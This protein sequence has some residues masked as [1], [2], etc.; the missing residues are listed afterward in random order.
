[1]KNKIFSINQLSTLLKKKGINK[2]NIILCHGV[3]DVIHLGHIKYF[4]SAKKINGDKNNFLIVTATADKFINK[5][6]NRPFFNETVRSEMLSSIEIIDAVAISN[7]ASS[8]EVI[9][10]I[11]P[12]YYVK[13][14]DYKDNTLDKSGKIYL[15][16]KAVKKFGGK[17]F[18]TKDE[19]YSS[20]KILN[21]SEF[22]FS[23]EQREILKKIK[24]KFDFAYVEKKI[25]DLKKIDV[26]VLGEI[27]FD[28]YIFG[29]VI[30]KSGKEPHLVQIYEHEESFIGGSAAVARNI[31]EFVKSVKL[32]SFFGNEKKYLTQIKNSFQKNISLKSFKPFATFS[33]ILK[34]RFID[35]NSKY[36][37][38]GLYHIQEFNNNINNKFINHHLNTSKSDLL[39]VTDYG[40]SLISEITIEKIKKYFKFIAVNAQ[41]NSSNSGLH[42]IIKY[43]NVDLIV[44]NETELRSELKDNKTEII[45]LSKLFL[46]KQRLKNLIITRGSSGAILV[47]NK[48]V[49]KCPAFSSNSI[50][51]V[52]AGD[53]M[54][55]L[56]SLCLKNKID[57]Q[58][59]LLIGCYA[60]FES[61]K[62]MANKFHISRKRMINF[63]EYCLK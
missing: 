31:A 59:S 15:E 27:I 24:N 29:N 7:T 33:S 44:V 39:I 17:M 4:N 35:H 30:G 6:F 43:K 5:G 18:Y 23:K 61:V 9:K 55:S 12:G 3:F 28:K 32:I 56:V 54:L 19:V 22:I 36:K 14:P 58:L 42:S 20:T 60:G 37:L 47:D 50:D 62:Y 41:L 46:K 63:L 16:K 10:K 40:H 57:K 11:Q 48:N 34:E 52:G 25:N 13:G 1:M 51:K 2:K 45:K 38:H 21:N 8:V 49:Y 53:S 26:T